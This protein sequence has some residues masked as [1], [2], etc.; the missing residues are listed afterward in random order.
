LGRRIHVWR[1]GHR[2][3]PAGELSSRSRLPAR[4]RNHALRPRQLPAQR[5][6]RRSESGNWLCAN[7]AQV[8]HVAGRLVALQA[9]RD[10]Q[11]SSA[12]R[13]EVRTGGVA[14][15]ATPA[16]ASGKELAGGLWAMPLLI[17]WPASI[18]ARVSGGGGIRTRGMV[19]HTS[20]FKTDAFD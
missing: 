1:R 5:C 17:A 16:A 8:R 19:A 3:K 2:P 15:L 13:R 9:R 7:A 20:V 11:R 12:G 10:G 4:R 14:A 18:L 6:L